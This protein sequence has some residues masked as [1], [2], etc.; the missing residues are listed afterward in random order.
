[1]VIF[2]VVYDCKLGN[3]NILVNGIFVGGYVIIGVNLI[4][5]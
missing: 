5:Y 2:Y 4:F 1:M 3:Y